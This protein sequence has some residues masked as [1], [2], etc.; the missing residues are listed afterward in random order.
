MAAVDEQ[1]QKCQQLQLSFSKTLSRHMNKLF[2]HQVL[3]AVFLPK[4]RVL[5]IVVLL[6]CEGASLW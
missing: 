4:N 5:P 1:R 6:A 3:I 2:I